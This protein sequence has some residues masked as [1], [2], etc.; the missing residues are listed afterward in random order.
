MYVID[1]T[2]T[3]LRENG[4]VY[5]SLSISTIWPSNVFKKCAILEFTI[6]YLI[7][8]LKKIGKHFFFALN[9]VLQ[10]GHRLLIT[11]EISTIRWWNVFQY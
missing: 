2:L 7:I 6:Y 11:E 1:V 4:V 10:A 8:I 5:L 9:A 3:S